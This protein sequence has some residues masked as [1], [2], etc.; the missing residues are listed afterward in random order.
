MPKSQIS[1]ISVNMNANL[2]RIR[3]NDYGRKEMDL[4]LFA[5]LAYGLVVCS[6]AGNAFTPQEGMK[7]NVLFVPLFRRSHSYRFIVYRHTP[8]VWR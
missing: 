1:I 4:I 7:N 3:R 8:N 6:S 2:T 5:V